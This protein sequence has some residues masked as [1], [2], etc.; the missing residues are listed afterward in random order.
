[1]RSI[2]KKSIHIIAIVIVCIIAITQIYVLPDQIT[3]HL[4]YILSDQGA[5]RLPE[6]EQIQYILATQNATSLTEACAPHAKGPPVTMNITGATDSSTAR[7]LF[8]TPWV[9]TDLW[10][11]LPE[12]SQFTCGGLTCLYTH[13]K[14]L[15][16]NS[17]VV[18]FY[19]HQKKIDSA[20]FQTTKCM[21]QHRDR[22]QYWAAHFQGPP[23]FID[24]PN[25]SDLNNVFNLTATYHH[26][27][28]IHMPYGF[29]DRHPGSEKPRTN[30]A[31]DKKGLVSWIVSHC[32]THNGRENY[33]DELQKYIDVE[34]YGECEERFKT[35]TGLCN[36]SNGANGSL[37]HDACT[38][39]NSYKFYLSFEN[40]NCVDYLTEKTYKVLVPSMTTVPVIMSGVDDLTGILPPGS[41]I[42]A[43][44]FP[45]PA[46]LA[47][48]L[49]MLDNDDEK[50]NAYFAWRSSY[51]CRFSWRPLTFCCKLAEIY[52]RQGMLVTDINSIYGE[53]ENCE[54]CKDTY[55]GKRLLTTDECTA[56]HENDKP[57]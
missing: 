42:D 57:P 39:M 20:T 32:N 29:C 30:Y 8:W 37:C 7:I 23:S 28:D 46:N 6:S 27:A 56:D 13:D 2:M 19:F 21:P 51:R 35:T 49:I 14:S 52:G 5:P 54:T 45:S 3:S 18:M 36:G 53:K 55:T 41:F 4:R 38:T 26:K 17:D 48:H 11:H 40:T 34:I 1:M 43:T 33:V 25:M 50:Y 9:G 31:E 47:R 22:G 44:L 15:Y 12:S 16:D 10:W 24:I